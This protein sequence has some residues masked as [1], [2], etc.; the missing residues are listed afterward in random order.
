MARATLA[1]NPFPQFFT[2]A[3][4]VAAGYKIYTYLAGTSTPVS[5][6]GDADMGSTNTNPVTVLADG[7]AV[8][9]LDPTLTYKFVLTTPADVAVETIDGISAQPLANGNLDVSGRAGESI[10]AGQLCFASDGTG[11]LTL[12]RWYL[13]DKGTSY[14]SLTASALGFS[15]ATLSTGNTGTFRTSGRMTGL[16]GLTAGTYYSVGT[17][18]ALATS[19]SLNGT[20]Q[21]YVGLGDSTTSL[22]VTPWTLSAAQQNTVPAIIQTF[23]IQGGAAVSTGVHGYQYIPFGFYI[24]GATLIADQSGS[25]V[26]DIWKD[27]YANALP[28]VAD[29]ITAS[30]KPTISAAVKGQT[31]ALTGWTRYIPAGSVLGFNVDS[32]T[33][34]TFVTLTLSGYVIV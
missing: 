19:A 16:S 15:L 33:S 29:T 4:V 32:C 14:K 21:R 23:G 8:M 28:T 5:T 9:F 10:T 20:A 22:L 30:D 31:T 24:M 6:Y 27:T 11:G 3:G 1:P 34:C 18:G 26:V 25:I 2:D 17:A 7:R 12:G 13:A